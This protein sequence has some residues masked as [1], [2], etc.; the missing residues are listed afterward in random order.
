[1]TD[2]LLA[3][4]LPRVR[5]WA[6]RR[7]EQTLR[8]QGRT[9]SAEALLW[10]F[11]ADRNPDV[12]QSAASLLWSYDRQK[13]DDL[14][15]RVIEPLEA[16]P[17]DAPIPLMQFLRHQQLPEPRIRTVLQKLE[18]K[19][20]IECPLCKKPLTQGERATHL[21]TVHGYV[22]YQGDLMPVQ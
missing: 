16:P 7:V 10:R 1:T 3:S 21:Q 5:G 11:L 19:R 20:P 2:S 15:L 6:L 18:S 14:L 22:F 13:T 4:A 12:R 9:D 17:L 8:T